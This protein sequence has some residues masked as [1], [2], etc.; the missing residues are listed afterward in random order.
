MKIYTLNE[1]ESLNTYE[2]EKTPEQNKKENQ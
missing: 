2:I 1:I